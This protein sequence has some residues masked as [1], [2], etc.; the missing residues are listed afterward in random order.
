MQI[1]PMSAADLDAAAEVPRQVGWG[2]LR[3]LYELGLYHP[4]AYPF[5]AEVDGRV[6]G[7]SLGTV[8]GSVGW[9]GQIA[10]LP[11]CRGTGL[12]TALT[13]HLM[14]HLTSLGCRTQLL[15]ATDMGQPIYEKLGFAVE[16]HYR[17]FQGPSLPAPPTDPRLRPLTA[18]D[19]P[20]VCALDA[21][22][23][24]EDRSAYLQY[25][26]DAGWVV[27]GRD[28]IDG[29]FVPMP[30]GTGPRI[31]RT[32]EA[33][34]LLVDLQRGLVGQRGEASARVQV[35]I[36][37]PAGIAGLAERRFVEIVRPARMVYGERLPQVPAGVWG[38]F[39]GAMG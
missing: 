5:V 29:F 13:R 17:R 19:W 37:S 3:T 7:T 6:V 8:R 22:T 33:G 35:L 16:A 23:T 30:W 18:A 11:E 14:A 38:V 26:G 4:Q 32:A 36:D 1:R 2:D 10:V 27:D 25:Y 34:L 28:G 24:G 15:I 21:A 9:V 20:A 39:G 12:G 31:A